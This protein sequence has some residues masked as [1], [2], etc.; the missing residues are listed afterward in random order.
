MVK[1]EKCGRAYGDDTI[2]CFVSVG[3]QLAGMRCRDCMSALAAR[4]YK[5][6]FKEVPNGI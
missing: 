2:S 5:S 3:I 6:S 1:C 4:T